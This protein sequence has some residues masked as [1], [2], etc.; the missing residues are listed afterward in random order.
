MSELLHRVAAT[1]GGQFD[2]R[3]LVPL[4]QARAVLEAMREPPYELVAAGKAADLAIDN[5]YRD[6]DIIPLRSER[7]TAIWQAMLDAALSK[8]TV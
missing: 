8:P 6:S 4:R 7:V 1:L 2:C 5:K 3:G